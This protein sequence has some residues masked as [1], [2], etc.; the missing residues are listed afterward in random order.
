MLHILQKPLLALLLIVP[1]LVAAAEGFARID[2]TA[3][4]QPRALQ[5]AIVTYA[6]ADGRDFS[7]D[8]ISAIHIGDRDYYRALNERFR[9]YDALLFELVIPDVHDAGDEIAFDGSLL[10]RLQIGLKDVLGLTFQLDEIDYAAPNFVHADMS[11]TMLAE[12]MEERG[13]S[14]YVYFWRLF[15]AAIDDY[16]RD[17]LGLADMQAMTSMLSASDDEA[18]KI[19]IAYEMVKATEDGDIL[20]DAN[21]SALITARNEHAMRV[22]RDQ[23]DRGVRRVGL[24]YGAAHMSDFEVRLL[25]ELGLERVAVEWADAWRLAP[26]AD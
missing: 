4:G 18:L 23:L 19:A 9:A 26:D 24:F 12:S 6:P 3:P 2:E 10:S 25:G 7:V 17:P 8:L 5:L 15:Y 14:L 20:G 21:G 16:A 1:P 13:E 22:L 11:S